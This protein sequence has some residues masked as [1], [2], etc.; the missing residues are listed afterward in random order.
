MNND[1]QEQKPFKVNQITNARPNAPRTTS[2]LSGYIANSMNAGHNKTIAYKQ[3]MAGEK[4]LAYRMK[5]NFQMLTP[6]TPNYQNVYMTVRTY[7]VPNSRV[8]KNAEKFTAQKG[9]ASEI[10]ITKVPSLGG[11]TI[12]WAEDVDAGE[13]TLLSN[14]TLW[15]DCFISSYLPRIGLGQSSNSP[16]Y[17]QAILPDVSALPL[18][19][20]VAIYN[21]MERNKEFDEVRQ[22]YNDDTVSNAEWNSY[23]PQSHQMNDIE[24]FT[25]RAKRENSYYS[26]YRTEIQGFEDAYP[27]TDMSADRSL[28]TWASW[29]SKISEG[30]QQAENAQKNDWDIIA[31]IRGSRV[32]TEGKVQKIGEK[33]FRMNYAS[34]TQNTYNN[35]ENIAD[36]FRVM[37]KQGA[38]SY[39]EVDIPLYEGVE[40]IEEGYIHVIATVSADT[41][42]EGAFDRLELNVNALD[43]YRP[44]MEGDKQDVLYNI[45]LGTATYN[46]IESAAMV[47][48]FKRKYSEY[49]KL[50]NIVG[51][52]MVTLPYYQ[53]AVIGGDLQSNIYKK[54]EQLLTNS[55]FQMFELSDMAYIGLDGAVAFK[56]SW[57]D[58]S[59][60]ALNRNQAIT[61]VVQEGSH[62]AGNGAINIGGQN[63]VFFVGVC[64]CIADLP[65]NEQI[66]TNYTKWGEH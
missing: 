44:D 2:V 43:Q 36:E 19:G 41:V 17:N 56:N 45:E 11:K 6:L 26:D 31:Q 62:I 5:A 64:Q 61:N 15:R 8:W 32:L 24:Y 27:P 58:Y 20:R 13:E 18:R 25:M 42:F 4:H 28:I 37:G 46:G 40:F 16:A 60:L 9:G 38:Y 14:T 22:E 52:D 48:G 66:K 23:F 53:T 30:R 63:Q 57:K 55:T 29:E 7:F 51:G 35:N 54:N 12:P 65:I 59:D 3:V 10:K 34:I 21:D 47:K 1:I 50:P 49:F 33:T 39:T